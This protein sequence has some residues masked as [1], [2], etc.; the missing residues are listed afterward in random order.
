MYYHKIL[1]RVVIDLFDCFLISMII[2]I[3]CTHY[4]KSYF[5]EK[6]KME[7]LRQDLIN[8]SKLVKSSYQIITPSLPT[9]AQKIF[10][11]AI[12]GIRGG[13]EELLYKNAENIK[14]LI[15][16][17]LLIVQKRINNPII[18]NLIFS[19]AR[20][21][22]HLILLVFKIDV[23][24]CVDP[25]TGQS[26]I[27]TVV[28]GGTTGFIVSW[29]G[30]GVTLATNLLGVVFLSRSLTQQV[31]NHLE[32]IKFR[33]QVLNLVKDEEFQSTIDRIGIKKRIETNKLKLKTL[34][35]EKNPAI[36]QAAE[37][38]G[39]FEEKPNPGPI[40]STENSLYN[41]YLKKLRKTVEKVV[42]V[43][44]NSDIID[45]DFGNQDRSINIPPIRIR[46]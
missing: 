37:H 25:L 10:N 16:S 29:I 44:G 3:Y 27:M 11:F 20:C 1:K 9:K 36:K 4:V 43:E 40:K 45:V 31:S 15:I 26:I 39:I 12:R 22:L 7:R 42:D 21:Y 18:F 8:K 35:W 46:D 13:N 19:L 41:R 34:N 32:Y 24:Y 2:S 6:Q 17:L 33:N 14:E 5:S 23:K 30:V 28:F 38:L